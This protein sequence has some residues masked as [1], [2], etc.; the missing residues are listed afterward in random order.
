MARIGRYEIV[1]E[2]GRGAMGV[3]YRARDPKIGR[4]LAVKTVRLAEH[5]DPE[6]IADLRER[7]FREAQSAGRLSH[8]GIVTIFDAD[9][10]GGLAY[11][12]MEL[13]EGRKLSEYRVSELAPETRIGFIADLLS[14]AGSA[15][16]YAHAKG[17][18]HRDIKP[19]NI[20]VTS[21]GVKIMDFGVARI[22]SSQLTRTGTIIGTPN[23]MSPEQVRAEPID[24][25]SDQFSLG[26]IV[27][28]MLTDHKPFDAP[29]I[30]STLFKLVNEGPAPI[31]SVDPRI[32]GA[33]EAVVAR[34]LAKR[35]ADRF[36][37]C[38][39]F[40]RAFATAAGFSESSGSAVRP[41]APRHPVEEGPGA[42][43]RPAARLP[44]QD[45]ITRDDTV[46]GDLEDRQPLPVGR[47]PPVA[48]SAT[49]SM[50][51]RDKPAPSRW[52]LLIFVLLMAAVGALSVLLVRHPD[53]LD[54][55]IGLLDG[56]VRQENSTAGGGERIEI[57][58][59]ATEE[60][61]STVPER[62]ADPP[63]VG[64]IAEPQLGEADPVIED[65][66]PVEDGVG[67]GGAGPEL[68]S[69]PSDEA[70]DSP[71]GEAADSIPAP[72]TRTG[73]VS[74][75]V[76][77]T[78]QVDGVMVTID[79]NRSWRCIT[80]CRIADVPLGDHTVVATRSG[81]GLQRRTITVGESGLA[82]NMHLDPVGLT[83][84]VSSV[85]PGA[86]IFL[87][88]QDTGNETNAG[89][90][91]QPGR[92]EIRVVHGDLQASRTVE[93]AEEELRRVEFRLGSN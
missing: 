30:T 37:N 14:M 92:Y 44:R 16:D 6:E 61:G 67:S 65:P 81:Y 68:G 36:A 13:V 78:S 23:Y 20:M 52:P 66:R 28:E 62:E 41:L 24:G 47:L 55:P 91:V 88:G 39:A 42:G 35:P 15:L 2:L 25:R 93:L 87:N 34:V 19:A 57:V 4:E 89:L 32:P 59:G 18:V 83:L 3:V 50:E 72:T 73:P 64:G 11:F 86:R 53:L 76:M 70:S 71:V 69:A 10:E 79:E 26:V 40:A 80:P 7:L 75:S 8:P 21:S 48:E 84:F 54:D 51:P 29:N 38:T 17:V 82:V 45:S 9:E 43:N 1:S 5:A 90:S 56:T 33:L 27:Y 60:P 77:F 49:A 12:T 63:P 22:S 85:P 74:A 46:L 31:R 58:P